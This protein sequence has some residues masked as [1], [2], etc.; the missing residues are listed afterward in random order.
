MAKLNNR[1]C[2]SCDVVTPHYGPICLSC[3]D[4]SIW[5]ERI[6]PD[7]AYGIEKA[8]SRDVLKR[9]SDGWRIDF[10]VSTSSRPQDRMTRIDAM[11]KV[12]WCETIQKQRQKLDWLDSFPRKAASA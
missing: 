11:L 1:E 10:K 6:G 9:L 4:W 12:L 5:P 7:S 8:D 2:E 3:P